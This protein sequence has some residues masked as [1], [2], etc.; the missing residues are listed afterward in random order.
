MVNGVAELVVPRVEPV[1]VLP[2]GAAHGVAGGRGAGGGG[3]VEQE[4]EEEEQGPK[5]SHH[6]PHTLKIVQFEPSNFLRPPR[7]WKAPFG[8]RPLL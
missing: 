5:A 3:T 6:F 2:G 4:Q 1:E 8:A 7:L